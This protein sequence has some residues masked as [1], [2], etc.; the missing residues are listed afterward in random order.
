MDTYKRFYKRILIEVVLF[1]AVGLIILLLFQ[2]DDY[3]LGWIWGCSA[4]LVYFTILFL[5]VYKASL[6]PEPKAIGYMRRTVLVR[7]SVALFAVIV[8]A[9]LPSV[10]ILATVIGLLGF[11]ILLY[12]DH[13]AV[14]FIKPDDR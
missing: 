8:A 4:T 7:M 10:N 3:M 11:K 14:R 6:M 1:M 9:F 5:Q 12:V 2:G 13:F